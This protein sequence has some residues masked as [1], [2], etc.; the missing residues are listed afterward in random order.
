MVIESLGELFSLVRGEHVQ[1]M[2]NSHSILCILIG[3]TVSKIDFL[4]NLLVDIL[5]KIFS[6]SEEHLY[7]AFLVS[8]ELK[9]RRQQLAFVSVGIL[10]PAIHKA[11]EP[12]VKLHRIHILS[13]LNIFIFTCSSIRN[14]L[15][16]TS[17][18]D[19]T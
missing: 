1:S 14:T 17:S 12:S 18:P 13:D 6:Q 11:N 5:E 16:L 2:D 3:S 8:S 10:L 15:K 19:L 9:K 7:A 4:E